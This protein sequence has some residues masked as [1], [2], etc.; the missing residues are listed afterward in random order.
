MKSKSPY[1]KEVGGHSQ[2]WRCDYGKKAQMLDT[3]LWA[4]ECGQPLETKKDKDS[5]LPPSEVLLT[6][7]RFLTSRV[8]KRC[9][10]CFK[11]LRFW[12]F[13]TEAVGN[14]YIIDI[15][16]LVGHH[17]YTSEMAL[18]THSSTLAWKIPWMEEPGG[19]PSMGL[20]RVGHDWSTLA[21]A[22]ASLYLIIRDNK[23]LF[24]EHIYY[25]WFKVCVS[26][27]SGFSSR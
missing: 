9:F 14:K 6:C 27:A 23:N 25:R 22:A 12:Q 10:S 15:L 16:Y 1:Q 18:A 5:P 11:P 8:V 21:A 3:G 7:F 24:Y 4:K 26:P 20:H 17:R 13:V 2:R 19:L